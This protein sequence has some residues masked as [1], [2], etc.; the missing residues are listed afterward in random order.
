MAECI[1]LEC[2]DGAPF[3][4]IH[5]AGDVYKR[6]VSFLGFAPAD[7]P[8]VI[9]L[10]A[11]DNPKPAFP[12]SNTTA[13]GWYISGGNMAALM[14]GELLED[15]LGHLGVE[16]TYTANADVLVPNLSCLLYT[17]RCV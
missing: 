5:G 1:A 15:I 12:G 6:Q 10:L 2:R 3:H 11:Y 13:G 17:S 4:H 9:I 14:A 7:D 16:K 8:Q